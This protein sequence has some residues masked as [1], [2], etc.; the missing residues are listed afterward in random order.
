MDADVIGRL[1][2]LERRVALLEIRAR[3]LR[4]ASYRRV[5][6]AL[7]NF[8]KGPFNDGSLTMT[9]NMIGRVT[10]LDDRD[11]ALALS[12]LRQATFVELVKVD[13]TG[14]WRITDD[15]LWAIT[16]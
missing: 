8:A 6:E 2:A 10:G 1:L 3:V 14:H 12:Q 7:G 5:L 13:G 9:P 11:L 4:P 15:G 16:E